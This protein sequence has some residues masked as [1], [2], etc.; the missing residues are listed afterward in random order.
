[1]P[2]LTIQGH[3]T[4][5]VERGTRLVRAIEDLGIN[6]LHRCGGHAKCTTCRVE[7]ISGEP[8]QMTKAEK[9]KWKDKDI[10]NLRLSCQ[11]KIES[12]MTIKV[13]NTTES[14]GL[15]DP[16]DTPADHITPEPEWIAVK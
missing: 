7:F 11:I 1:M 14:T 12:D 13:I 9:E 8:E 4:F 2:K 6:I 16:G 15:K 5:E 3:G 10:S